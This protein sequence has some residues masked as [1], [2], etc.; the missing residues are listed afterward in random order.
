MTLETPIISTQ[1]EPFLVWELNKVHQ[2]KT[3]NLELDIVESSS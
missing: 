3:I 1:F 2:F